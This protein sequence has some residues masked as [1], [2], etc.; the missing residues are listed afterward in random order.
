MHL[1]TAGL[2]TTVR[3]SSPGRKLEAGRR[4]PHRMNRKNPQDPSGG[5]LGLM[6]RQRVKTWLRDVY[7]E[8]DDVGV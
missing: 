6:D 4:R 3:M 5:G 7:R 1:A 8:I 2:R